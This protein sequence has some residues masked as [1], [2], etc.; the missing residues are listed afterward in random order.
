MAHWL[1][2]SEPDAY[3]IDDLERDGREPWD[4]IRN[5]Q[6]RN[7]MRDDMK[8][9]D[10]VFFYH[11]NCKEPGIVG[12]MKVASEPYPDPT[13]FDRKSNYYDPKSPRDDPRWCLVDV[14]FVRKLGRTITLS[15]IKAA[16]GLDGLILTRKGNRLSIMPIEKKHWNKLLS[17][18]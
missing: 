14:E 4:G 3:S 5:Y 12:I 7:M 15:E 18:E 1:M 11:S 6:A 8:I 10:E 9:G 17:L 16:R 13:Q 2:K